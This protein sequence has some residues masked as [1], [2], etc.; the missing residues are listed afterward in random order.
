MY[1]QSKMMFLQHKNSRIENPPK[2]VQHCRNSSQ[3]NVHGTSLYQDCYY[4]IATILLLLLHLLL[5]LLLGL[6]LITSSACSA[7]SFIPTC[8]PLLQSFSPAA[9]LR[10]AFRIPARAL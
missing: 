9:V 2:Y 4:N 6:L 5:L 3:S 8:I 1:T 7:L 10:T